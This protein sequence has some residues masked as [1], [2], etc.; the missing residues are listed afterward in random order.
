MKHFLGE[1]PGPPA[2]GRVLPLKRGVGTPLK[3]VRGWLE[4]VDF[5]CDKSQK[6]DCQTK[7]H[8]PYCASQEVVEYVMDIRSTNL[9]VMG[10]P[11]ATVPLVGNIVNNVPIFARKSISRWFSLIRPCEDTLQ[12]QD[13]HC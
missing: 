7:T 10:Q 3:T 9:T 1:D 12:L 11:I 13:A 5:D 8:F 4:Q 6:H 2:L